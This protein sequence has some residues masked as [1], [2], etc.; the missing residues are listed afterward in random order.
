MPARLLKA[1]AD[2]NGRIF[3]RFPPASLAKP[4]EHG[5]LSALYGA[6]GV[7][8]DPV[9]TGQLLDVG[10]DPNDGESLYL[11][12]E[13]VRNTGSTKAGDGSAWQQQAGSTL[14]AAIARASSFSSAHSVTCW[15]QPPPLRVIER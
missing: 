2:P 12:L 4:D 15:I 14:S 11:S 5:P 13:K 3:N 9:L 7:G 1:R 10:A 6:A 8:R